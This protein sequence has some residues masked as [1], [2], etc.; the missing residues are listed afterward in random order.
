MSFA[1]FQPHSLK[2]RLLLPFALLIV[3]LTAMIGAIT[4]MAGASTVSSLSDRMLREM[5]TR[6]QQSIRFHVNGSAAVLEAAFPTGMAAPSDVRAQWLELRSRLWAA[7]TLHPSTN[8]YVYYGN[9]AGQGIGLKRLPDGTAELRTRTEDR[10]HRKYST[11][12][13]I[14][15]QE[16]FSHMEENLFDP[17]ERPWFQRAARV[18][19]HT[20]TAVYIDFNVK[21]LVLT[22]ARRVLGPT[23]E[24]EGVVATD[25]SLQALRRVV[26]ELGDSIQGRAFIIEPDG[27]LVA[28]SGMDNIQRAAD[29]QLQR[30]SIRNGTDPL[31]RSVYAQIQPF[32]NTPPNAQAPQA[33]TLHLNDHDGNP[34]HAAFVRVF[35]EAGLDWIAVVTVPRATLLAD[36][37]RLVQAVLILG[38]ACLLLALL[39][40]IR[41][42]GRVAD[43]VSTL[44]SVV[45]RVRSGDIHAPIDSSRADEI[46]QLAHNV[47]QMRRELFTDRLTSVANRSAMQHH[48][49][50]LI[51]RP[52]AP[53][54]EAA[55]FALL[56]LDLNLFKPLNDRWGHDNGDRA[57]TEVAQRLQTR[58]RSH[59]LVA[60]LGGDEF[61]IVLRG[62]SN[63]QEAQS[64]SAQLEA[65][66]SEPLTTLQGIP[67][68]EQVSLGASIG[69]ALYPQDAQDM[70]QLMRHADQQMYAQKATRGPANSR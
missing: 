13:R 40:G 50:A 57:L 20:W 53:G 69:I 7:T 38:A 29:G 10:Q 54:A 12:D 55:P 24:F 35:D 27:E 58:L 64:V 52:A 3:M 4:Y 46:G 9:I 56:F 18:E 26:D 36:V 11:L 61:V 49:N 42:F 43:D 39:L 23:E 22:R 33:R 1:R 37:S 2:L 48:L 68:G 31:I 21:D 34:L 28:A 67:E 6:I 16:R 59:D 65:L 45:S 70:Q 17:R 5:A 66:V 47:D 63:L 8:D 60:R 44:S 41:Q 14:D 15:G 30:L 51:A 32:F 62:M 25:V 19:R